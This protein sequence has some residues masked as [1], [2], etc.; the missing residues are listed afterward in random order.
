MPLFVELGDTSPLPHGYDVERRFNVIC[1]PKVGILNDR[2]ER[3]DPR[4]P[5]EVL[6]HN[7]TRFNLFEH[8]LIT[9]GSEKTQKCWIQWKIIRRHMSNLHDFLGVADVSLTTVL[10]SVAPDLLALAGDTNAAADSIGISSPMI[11]CSKQVKAEVLLK[12]NAQL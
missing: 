8:S 7:P 11:V 1:Y 10:S 12:V 5:K 9:F 2:L 4:T 3:A 6:R